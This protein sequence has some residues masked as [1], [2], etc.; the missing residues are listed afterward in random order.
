MRAIRPL[1]VAIFAGALALAAACSDRTLTNPT[2]APSA[3]LI[4]STLDAT[5]SLLQTTGLLK[6]S[7]LPADTETA[8][9]GASGGTLTIGPHTLRIPAG[10]LTSPVTI[11]GSIVQGGKVNGVHFEPEGLQFQQTAYLTMSYANCNLLGS[12]APKRIAYT[13][14]ALQVLEYLLSV[15]NLFSRKVTGQVHH[16]SDYVV[17]W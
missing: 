17:S 8:T 6:C 9:I 2:P 12:L 7:Q 13:T 10:A 16:F 14:D 4:G 5:T 3:D 11:T 1:V 15:D